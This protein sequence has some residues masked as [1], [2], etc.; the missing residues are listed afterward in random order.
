MPILDSSIGNYVTISG[1][2]YSYFAG[3]N[4]LGLADH[5]AIKKASVRSIKKYGNNF[6]ASRCTTGTADIHLE[7]EKK[8]AAFMQ[9]QDAVVFASGYM[10]N[11]I[12]LDTL[13][14]RYSSVF[15][16]ELAHPSITGS[17]PREIENIRYFDHC[18]VFH[19]EN[20]L[21]QNKESNP[22]VITDG[23]FALS[24]EIAPLDKIYPLVEKY[25]AILVVDDAHSIGILGKNGRGTAEYF[26]LDWAGNI[27]SSGTMSKALGGYGGFISGT[28]ELIELIR[29]KSAAFQAST[30]LPPSLV[31]TGTASL[32]ILQN[33]P[34]LRVRLLDKATALRKEIIS[35]GFQT[36][37]DYTP[38]IPII[39]TELSKAEGLSLFLKNNRVIAP[40]MNYPVKMK[41]HMIR[42]TVSAGHTDA[43]IENLLIL[44]KKW[45]DKNGTR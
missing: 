16:D 39:W 11:G 19:L 7:L 10:S 35:L 25:H 31:A 33:Y 37:P 22:L 8:L 13:K 4:Y 23:V 27:Y 32:E 9:K 15:M 17:I 29:E 42:I 3:N 28:H 45:R 20:L 1:H 44:L 26:N 41:G 5:P 12:L 34:E 36:T 21:K 2:K 18:D 6:S 14:N 30:S 40:F 38:I 24:G 43:Q